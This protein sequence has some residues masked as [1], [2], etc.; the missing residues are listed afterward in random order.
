MTRLMAGRHVR[1][2]GHGQGGR[3]DQGQGA[4]D[5]GT[6]GNHMT[7]IDVGRLACV[8]HVLYTGEQMREMS[9]TLEQTRKISERTQMREI[10]Q[11]YRSILPPH[12]QHGARRSATEGSSS[13][14]L[15]LLAALPTGVRGPEFGYSGHL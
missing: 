1:A 10:F 14:W 9:R 8:S 4:H 7:M 6:A 3:T 11:P 13:L 5:A 2:D 15:G 12:A